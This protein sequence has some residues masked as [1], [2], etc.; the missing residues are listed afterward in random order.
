MKT[1]L[2][3]VAELLYTLVGLSIVGKVA[4][5]ASDIFIK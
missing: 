5:H 4:S 3:S 1:L 2:I